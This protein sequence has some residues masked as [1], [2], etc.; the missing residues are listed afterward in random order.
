M[1]GS[2]PTHMALVIDLARQRGVVSRR[3]LREQGLPEEYL[4]KLAATGRLSQLSPGVYMDVMAETGEH[5]ELA[6][7]A[8]RVPRAVF[9]GITALGLHELTSQ[10]AHTVEFAVERDSWAP[11][12]DWPTTDVFHLSGAS[13]S[14]GIE[15]HTIEGGVPIRVYSVAKTVA[16]LFKFRSRFGLDVALEALQEGWKA[17]RFTRNE[18]A[19]CANACRVQNVMRPYLEMLS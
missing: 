1:H 4:A 5:L 19:V 16:D 3:D 12:L 13:F 15:E 18:L 7:V 9:F 11:V 8:K 17:R 6:V 2:T 10:V 14:T